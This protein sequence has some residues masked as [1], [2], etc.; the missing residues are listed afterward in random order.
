MKRILT[1]LFI[2]FISFNLVSC[3]TN[4]QNQNTAAGV[5]AG[6]ALGG[7]AGGLIGTGGGQ[8]VAI[9]AGVV[10]GALI[11]GFIGHSMDSSDK[12]A[13]NHTMDNN[14]TNKTTKWKNKKTLATYQVTPTSNKITVKGNPNCRT[15]NTV[16]T[17]NGN[18][19]TSNG[20]A[21]RQA[22]GT[23]QAVKV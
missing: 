3:S 20:T 13:M 23:W 16:A 2:L 15:Y 8:A 22:D 6:G 1:Q 18:T 10:I 7:L 9:G 11:G 21:C 4:T 19:Q 14:P 17:L 5:L 12:A